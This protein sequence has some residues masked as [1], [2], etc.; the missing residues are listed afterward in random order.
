M[1][2]GPGKFIEGKGDRVPP[3]L[4]AGDEIPEGKDSVIPDAALE[5]SARI[6]ADLIVLG[7]AGGTLVMS[8]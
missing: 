7:G 2:V 3:P 6:V 1:A 5:E 4:K 8:R